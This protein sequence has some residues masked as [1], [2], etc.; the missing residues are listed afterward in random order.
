[1]KAKWKLKTGSMWREK[2]TGEGLDGFEEED[3]R[4]ERISG[5]KGC[6]LVR[7]RTSEGRKEDQE[8]V[9]PGGVGRG[10]PALAEWSPNWGGF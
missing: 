4:G 1:M 9:G 6:D 2:K 5:G 10:L 7:G 3:E 8:A